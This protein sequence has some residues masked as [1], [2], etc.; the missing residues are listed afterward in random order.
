MY[1]S[2]TGKM[3]NLREIRKGDSA[4]IPK[5]IGARVFAGAQARE[6]IKLQ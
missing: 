4:V 5:K 2:D 6:D 3:E 1:K